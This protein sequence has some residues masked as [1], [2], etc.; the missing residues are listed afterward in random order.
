MAASLAS[1]GVLGTQQK[2]QIKSFSERI[3]NLLK[4]RTELNENITEVFNEAKEAGFDSKIMRKAVKRVMT[5]ASVL[6]AEEEM[7]DAYVE[8]IQPDLFSGKKA[9]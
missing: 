7:I 3:I 9:A 2:T 1:G 4:E 6:A 5:D 8:A